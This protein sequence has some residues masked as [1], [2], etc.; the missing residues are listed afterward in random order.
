M[1]EYHVFLSALDCHGGE[2]QLGLT[3]LH[4]GPATAERASQ[5]LVPSHRPGTREGDES[6]LTEEGRG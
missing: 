4:P 2:L 5:E 6:V 3:V 1:P